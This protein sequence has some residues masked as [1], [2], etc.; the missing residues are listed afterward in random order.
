MSKFSGMRWRK[1]C[2]GNCL[3]L[4]TSATRVLRGVAAWEGVDGGLGGEDGG[5]EDDHVGVHLAEIVG[6]AVVSDAEL[7]GDGVVVAAG[8]GDDVVAVLDEA[9]GEELAEVAEADDADLQLA[10]LLNLGALL[11][12][13]VE[14]LGGVERARREAERAAEGARRVAGRDARAERRIRAPT[15]RAGRRRRPPP[16]ASFR[17][18][19]G[20]HS[21]VVARRP[22]R[23]RPA[24]RRTWCAFLRK[25]LVNRGGVA[26]VEFARTSVPRAQ[27]KVRSRAS[28]N[29]PIRFLVVQAAAA[30][31]AAPT[32]EESARTPGVAELGA[33][34]VTR[35]STSMPAATLR[36]SVLRLTLGAASARC[37]SPARSLARPHL[38][39]WRASD[40]WADARTP[41]RRARLA[42]VR[43]A[44]PLP[45][46]SAASATAN[47]KPTSPP[48]PSRR[49]PRTR[50]ASPRRNRRL[51]RPRPG[52][53]P[54]PSPSPA[55]AHP[56]RPITSPASTPPRASSPPLEPSARPPPPCSNTG[57]SPTPSSSARRPRS[58]F[59]FTAGA[60]STR[61]S[62]AARVSPR[63]PTRARV[64]EAKHP[65]RARA[66]HTRGVSTGK[67]APS[68]SRGRSTG[69]SAK[70]RRTTWR[71]GCSPRT[72][73]PS[74]RTAPREPRSV[75]GPSHVAHRVGHDARHRP[76]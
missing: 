4:R 26:R 9:L 49:P 22:R 29:P 1:S 16:R 39:A 20:T 31:G 65:A 36:S 8:G 35:V 13:E 64:A 54:S 48:P 6:V 67:D 46:A 75:L 72:P 69:T 45:A 27:D 62:A 23:R 40:D 74:P 34:G 44:T 11:R 30:R 63:P 66:T 25:G 60:S 71:S 47:D 70:R 28:S 51:A 33:R 53:D 3:T 17:C 14:R 7:G 12:L 32:V 37:A 24:S 38:T 58:R 19:S 76:E 18:P 57:P 5:A 41:P 56:A 55:P 61:A 15:T 68:S 43:P 21:R 42:S 2:L 73:R 59:R 50:P 52:P 10:L